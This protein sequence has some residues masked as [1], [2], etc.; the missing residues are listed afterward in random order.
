VTW[1]TAPVAGATKVGSVPTAVNLSTSY[2]FD[3][4]QLVTGDG[5][6]SMLIKSTNADGA[7]YYSKEG[8]T[9]SQAPQLQVTCG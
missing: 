9:T 5:T 2:L 6:V 8:G 7:R 4:K 1:S 3:V